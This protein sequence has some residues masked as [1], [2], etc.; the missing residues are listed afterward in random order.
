LIH[1]IIEDAFIEAAG[2]SIYDNLEPFL[3]FHRIALLYAAVPVEGTVKLAFKQMETKEKDT[4]DGE[5]QGG[6]EKEE[7]KNALLL[8]EYLNHMCVF[9]LY[10]MIVQ[11]EPAPELIDYVERTKQLFFDGGVCG[12]PKARY[13]YVQQ[14]FDII[15][16]LIPDDDETIKSGFLRKILS[17]SNT[18]SG[19]NPTPAPVQSA[20]RTIT[21]TRRMF[22]DLDGYPLPPR[23]FSKQF[24]RLIGEYKKEKKAA[25]KIVMSRSKTVTFKGSDLDCANIH[26][27][28][29]LIVTKPK[30]NLDLCRAYQNIYNK[31]RLSINSYNSRFAQLLKAQVPT[32]EEKKMFGRGITSSR[33]YDVKKRY[34]YRIT[35]DF[36]I[37]DIAIMLLID[38]SG[39]MKGERRDSAIV[40]SLILHE[41]LKKQGLTH[42]IV[43]HRASYGNPAV[44][45]NILV[46]FEAKEEEKYNIL[47]LRAEEGTREGLS[48][49]WAEKYINSKTYEE[50]K[51]IIVLSDGEPSHYISKGEYYYPPVSV[52]DTANAASKIVARGTD[53]IAVALDDGGQPGLACYEA[54]KKIY[55]SVISCTD[56]KRLTGQL[57]SIISKNLS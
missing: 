46:D 2:C 40:S 11:E 18:H 42:A 16:P 51:L 22:T 44:K 6:E 31:Y 1:N 20:G 27:G 30:P 49:F 25:I 10:P 55:P 38:G 53:I 4:E 37:P 23:S 56:L 24:G 21:I 12:E 5:E 29:K 7:K 28:I 32:R 45:H 17:G 3:Q 26:K 41:V 54:L 36:G 57:L 47:T 43:E 34:W 19:N 50:K 35:E 8:I 52:K 13:R 48:L 9:M 15:E 14:I 39:S 33:L